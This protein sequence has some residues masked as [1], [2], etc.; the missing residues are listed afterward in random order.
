[1]QYKSLKWR[2]KKMSYRDTNALSD[3]FNEILND[4]RFI[5][6]CTGTPIIKKN[7]DGKEF[8]KKYIEY[9]QQIEI[10]RLE[11]IH[12]MMENLG[13]AV[14]NCTREITEK[15]QKMITDCEMALNDEEKNILKQ[16]INA[17]NYNSVP[18]YEA[19][20][21]W[22]AKSGIREPKRWHLYQIAFALELKAYLPAEIENITTEEYQTSVN[23]LFNKIYNQRLVT[24]TA[25]EMIFIFCLK[26]GKKYTDAMRTY[27][28]YKESCQVNSYSV[29]IQPTYRHNN[30]TIFLATQGITNSEE[31][32]IKELIKLSP[33]LEDKYSSVFDKLEEWKEYFSKKDV[34]EYFEPYKKEKITRQKNIFI[35]SKL[36]RNFQLLDNRMKITSALYEN[37]MN[38]GDEKSLISKLEKLDVSEKLYKILKD[39]GKYSISAIFGQ[40]SQQFFSHIINNVIITKKDL[41]AY[42]VETG[43]S[44]Y[45]WHMDIYRNLSHN[46]IYRDLRKSII[47]AHFFHYWSNMDYDGGLEYDDYIGEINEILTDY[48]YL[49]LY[50][51]NSYDCFFMLCAKT[52]D[53]IETYYTV[54]NAIFDIYD[55]YNNEFIGLAD[56]HNACYSDLQPDELIF[57]YDTRM[58][59]DKSDVQGKILKT[60][61]KLSKGQ[62]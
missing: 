19:V 1:M 13:L 24:R 46:L 14:N 42:K 22:F 54:F 29:E 15:M 43:N 32:F 25:H 50:I 23:Y 57:D 7:A 45:E 3:V 16:D 5:F 61:Y 38:I 56:F 12:L 60:I 48:L 27:C 10:D 55:K 21:K 58:S 6:D 37:P 62:K 2:K 59:I 11:K 31:E 28:R 18:K 51:K 9:C 34:V 33:F 36:K 49:P 35:S 30:A 17:R 41:Y 39:Y 47:T 4:S 26:N 20:R 53:P 44:T 52:R 8:L 40:G